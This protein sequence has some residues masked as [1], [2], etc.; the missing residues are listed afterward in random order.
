MGTLVSAYSQDPQFTQFYSNKMYL[1]PSFVGATQQNRITSNIRDQWVGLKNSY[2]TYTLSYEHYFLNFNSGLG[3]ILMRD[4][5]G[6]GNLN[7]TG[8]GLQYSYDFKILETCHV[9]PGIQFSY[10]RQ[11][12]NFSKLLFSDQMHPNGDDPSSIEVPTIPS[13]GAADAASSVLFYSENYWM[14]ASFDH[15]L[16]PDLSLSSEKAY[17]NLKTS[18]FGGVTLIRRGKLL[19]P[20]GETVSLAFL[21]KQQKIESGSYFRQMD[22]GLYWYKKPLV[23]GFWYRGIPIMKGNRSDALAALIGLKSKYINIGYSYDFTVS[24]LI[25]NSLGSHELSLVYEFSKPHKKKKIHAIPC[26]EF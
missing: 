20:I 18:V 19:S 26:P 8:I 3:V 14:G 10:L 15:L 16:H 11:G 23:L 24:R 13:N 4:Q 7:L 25:G 9:R 5:A 12:L 6:A 17:I 22:C 21:Y 1:A 2:I